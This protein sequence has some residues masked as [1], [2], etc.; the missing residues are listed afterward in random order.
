MLPNVII[1]S[2]INPLI[3]NEKLVLDTSYIPFENSNNP[4][5]I[6]FVS[7]LKGKTNFNRVTNNDMNRRF[8]IIIDKAFIVICIELEYMLLLFLIVL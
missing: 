6:E 4:K 5:I 1:I 7:L 3:N 2:I 8:E